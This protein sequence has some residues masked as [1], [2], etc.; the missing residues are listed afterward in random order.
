M[1]HYNFQMQEWSCWSHSD[2]WVR[3]SFAVEAESELGLE[4][5]AHQANKRQQERG[6]D[7]E[8][9][10]DYKQ[11]TSECILGAEGDVVKKADRSHTPGALKGDQE[12]FHPG[13]N[14]PWDFFHVYNI[15]V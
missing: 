5:E 8:E 4:G 2:S 7:G 10:G 14:S 9:G 1:L 13:G 12:L 6:M 15:F 3:Q 11:F